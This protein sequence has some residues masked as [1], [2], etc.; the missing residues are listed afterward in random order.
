MRNMTGFTTHSEKQA[1]S[2]E[3]DHLMFTL[4]LKDGTF[5]C[6]FV[7]DNRK[8]AFTRVPFILRNSGRAWLAQQSASQCQIVK[9]TR[10]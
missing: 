7:A 9:A 3:L 2:E 8:S 5:V 10:A 1:A 4:Y 6:H